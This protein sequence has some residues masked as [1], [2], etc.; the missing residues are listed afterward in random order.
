[1]WASYRTHIH[2]DFGWATPINLGAN[3]NTAGLDAGASYFLAR[4]DDDASRGA[5]EGAEQEDGLPV[6]FFGSDRPGGLGQA[7]LYVSTRQS[8]GVFGPPTLLSELSSPFNDQ[9]P[10]IRRDGLEIFFYSGRPGGVG[11]NDLW[12]ATRET[13]SQVWRTPVKLG[14]VVN[15]TAN[16]FGLC[17]LRTSHRPR[18]EFGDGVRACPSDHSP[19]LAQCS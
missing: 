3:I 18:P 4:D 2:D 11:A 9:R 12:V 1:V 15:S 16:D 8:N 13:L 19:G 6:L 7:D 10:S 17:W 5:D 14:A